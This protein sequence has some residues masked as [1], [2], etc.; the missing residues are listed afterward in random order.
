MEKLLYEYCP[1]QITDALRDLV[2]FNNSE[3]SEIEEAIY[4]LREIA[5]NDLNLPC[6]KMLYSC[7][8]RLCYAAENGD[9]KSEVISE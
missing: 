2:G 7:L 3:W 9:F 5:R 1:D 6:W 4:Q 8:E